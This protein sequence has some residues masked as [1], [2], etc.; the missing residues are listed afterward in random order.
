M[1][2]EAQ[3]RLARS[4]IWLI[5]LL[6][7]VNFF[8]AR[9]APGTIEPYT[10]ACIRWGL[11]GV[12]LSL[13]AHAELRRAWRQILAVWYQYVALGFCGMVVCGAWVYLGAQST[14]AVNMALIYAAAPVLIAVG[15]VLWLQERMR[16]AQVLGVVLALSGVLHVVIK[17]E[18]G[19]L[20]A[21]RFVVGDAWM[22]AAM[23]SW[24]LYALLQKLWPSSIGASA[25]L[26]ATCWGA[27]PFLL[28]GSA[29][30]LAQPGTPALGLQAWML[31]VTVALLPGLG[32]YWIYAWAQGILGASKVAVSLYLGPLY[33]ALLAWL[34]LGEPLGWHHAVGA[35]LILPG[36]YL[37]SRLGSANSR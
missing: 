19:A 17:G 28:A 11:A 20:G 2:T 34:V 26:A 7:A 6:W 33:A 23:V 5:P 37:V 4:A 15:S 14:G 22:V 29:W 10:L 27:M 13:L 36:V 16:G 12:L 8:V 32:A 24:A 35:A 30:E 31:G 21:V 25:R 18:W 1:R 9:K 3:L